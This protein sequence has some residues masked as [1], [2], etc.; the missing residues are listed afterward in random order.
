M[1][2]IHVFEIDRSKNKLYISCSTKNI[3]QDF[4]KFKK[5]SQKYNNHNFEWLNT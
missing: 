5:S 4:D 2:Q 3:Q 1:Y